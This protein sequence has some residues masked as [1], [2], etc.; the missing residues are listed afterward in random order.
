MTKKNGSCTCYLSDQ[1]RLVSATSSDRDK[2]DSFGTWWWAWWLVCRCA[3]KHR[4]CNALAKWTR[5]VYQSCR[6]RKRWLS[7]SWDDN[8]DRYFPSES[9][10][11]HLCQHDSACACSPRRELTHAGWF[12]GPSILCCP[13]TRLVDRR[14]VRWPNDNRRRCKDSRSRSQWFCN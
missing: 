14:L 2:S 12:H 11:T 13:A 7:R 1:R 8:L 6:S 10:G 9:S 4:S 3:R 5:T